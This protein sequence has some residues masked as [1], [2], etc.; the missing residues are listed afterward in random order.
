MALARPECAPATLRPLWCALV[1]MKTQTAKV[2]LG[3]KTLVRIEIDD[4]LLTLPCSGLAICM[5]M[6]NSR[7]SPSAIVH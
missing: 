5:E 6:G 7:N 3:N 2:V 4:G 1:P